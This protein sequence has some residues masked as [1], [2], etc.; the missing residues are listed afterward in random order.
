LPI[1]SGPIGI[2]TVKN[3]ILSPAAQRFIEAA[4]GVAK[5]L[6]KKNRRRS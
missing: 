2:L 5:P 1:V 6:D 3:R 4:R